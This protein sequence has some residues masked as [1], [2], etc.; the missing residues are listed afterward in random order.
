VGQAPFEAQARKKEAARVSAVLS[1]HRG[2]GRESQAV[3]AVGLSQ[4]E[5]EAEQVAR[6][7]DERRRHLQDMRDIGGLSHKAEAAI[8]AE[9]AVRIS[10]LKALD[11]K[12]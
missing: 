8:K 3:V 7:I 11:K 5:E 1:K 10:E 12:S 6:E 9:I 4:R 2:G